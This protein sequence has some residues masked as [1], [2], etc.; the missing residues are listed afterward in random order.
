MFGLLDKTGNDN[1]TRKWITTKLAQAIL[2]TTTKKP[3]KWNNQSC[4]FHF[5]VNKT[6][7][8]FESLASVAQFTG[9][10]GARIDTE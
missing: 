6:K 1:L 8:D 4:T 2:V 9:Q 7:L 10:F 5:I 3:Q